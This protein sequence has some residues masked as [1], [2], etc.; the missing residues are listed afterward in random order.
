MFR[1]FEYQCTRTEKIFFDM[2]RIYDSPGQRNNPS[3]EVNDDHTCI[4]GSS[5]SI[6][7]WLV[8]ESEHKSSQ[9]L[10]TESRASPRKNKESN[11]F[12]K[13]IE[14]DHPIKNQPPKSNDF[15]KEEAAVILPSD[16]CELLNFEV[17]TDR[18]RTTVRCVFGIL[19]TYYAI[20]ARPILFHDELNSSEYEE[21][22]NRS[23]KEKERCRDM[24]TRHWPVSPMDRKRLMRFWKSFAAHKENRAITLKNSL[25]EFSWL[26]FRDDLASAGVG[27]KDLSLVL[28]VIM[29]DV[30]Y[31]KAGFPRAIYRALLRPIEGDLFSSNV[32]LCRLSLERKF[33]SWLVHALDRIQQGLLMTQQLAAGGAS[34]KSNSPCKEEVTAMSPKPSLG[35][36]RA[37]SRNIFVA[38]DTLRSEL[39]CHE[40]ELC[41]CSSESCVWIQ[42]LRFALALCHPYDSLNVLYLSDVEEGQGGWNKSSSSMMMSPPRSRAGAVSP[43]SSPLRTSA[44]QGSPL[45]R[46]PE[47]SWKSLSAK[48]KKKPDSPSVCCAAMFVDNGEMGQS[49]PM[50]RT[51]SSAGATSSSGR[52]RRGRKKAWEKV[53]SALSKAYGDAPQYSLREIPRPPPYA[54]SKQQQE[55]EVRHCGRGA[56]HGGGDMGHV[57]VGFGDSDDETTQ[58]PRSLFERDI[59]DKVFL[60]VLSFHQRDLHRRQKRRAQT[61]VAADCAPL[62]VLTDSSVVGG[63]GCTLDADRY[64]A[65][66]VF[67][68]VSALLQSGSDVAVACLPMAINVSFKYGRSMLMNIDI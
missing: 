32:S 48:S 12:R 52:V 2:K 11:S 10:L 7:N 61:A 49:S 9:F 67:S 36:K 15:L 57:A 13:N 19:T 26:F 22:D 41:E 59:V 21:E 8:N 50:D 14:R 58:P 20:V 51:V 24:V 31:P 5:A 47:V 63:R 42:M 68:T 46:S 44:G 27:G 17:L 62:V 66:S 38:V 29:M 6:A 35:V 18:L 40:S 3:Q 39:T 45:G 43:P 55:G 56:S 60:P 64:G 23:E 54:A 28:N 34:I 25:S 65:E 37:V 53:V 33:L 30:E 16:A 4:T 1:E